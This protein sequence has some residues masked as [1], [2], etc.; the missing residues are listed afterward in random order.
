MSDSIILAKVVLFVPMIFFGTATFVLTL[1][2]YGEREKY[3]APGGWSILDAWWLI[4]PYFPHG[5][6]DTPENHSKIRTARITNL[7]T[8]LFGAILFYI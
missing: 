5:L 8:W 2:L 6:P 7:L 1:S 3:E 4:L